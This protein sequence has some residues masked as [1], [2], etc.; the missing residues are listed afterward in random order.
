LEALSDE[1]E[2][3]FGTVPNDLA[4]D[5]IAAAARALQPVA[6]IGSL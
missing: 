2:E 3:P 1:I 4:L 6:G 5:A